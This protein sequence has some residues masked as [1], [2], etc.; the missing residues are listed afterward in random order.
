MRIKWILLCEGFGLDS[1]GALTAIGLNQNVVASETLPVQ[2]KRAIIIRLIDENEPA[3]Q[4]VMTISFS[5]ISPTGKVVSANTANVSIGPKKFSDLPGTGEIP[6]ELI[7]NLSEYG[8]YR[9]SA[10][11]RLE[12]D[13]VETVAE[14]LYVVSSP[15]LAS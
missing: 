15:G 12:D 9:V 13:R 7:L 10:E 11:I 2:T 1:K 6:A 4:G 5:V 3:Y 8:T 14:Y